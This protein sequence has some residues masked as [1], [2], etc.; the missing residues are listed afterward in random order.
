MKRDDIIF[1]SF[2]TP[3]YEEPARKLVKSLDRWGLKH[4]VREERDWGSWEANIVRKPAFIWQMMCQHP[5]ARAVVW[6]DADAEVLRDPVRLF[7]VRR[8]MA[9]HQYRW[10]EPLCITLYC[11][12]I[13]KVRKFIKR[14]ARVAKTAMGKEHPADQ[15]SL[16]RLL[17]DKSITQ[18]WLPMRYAALVTKTKPREDA[19]IRAVRWGR[20]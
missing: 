4:D 3:L 7:S 9:F 1:V 5:E 8:N 20:K 2:Y 12:N 13:A 16:A 10:R 17:K 18:Q 11:E 6:I 15:K 14:W 19:V